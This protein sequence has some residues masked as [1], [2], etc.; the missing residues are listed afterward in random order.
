MTSPTGDAPPERILLDVCVWGGGEG[1]FMA[2]WVAAA[3]RRKS[4]MTYV[5]SY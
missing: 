3:V 5:Q 2:A 1:G 4:A